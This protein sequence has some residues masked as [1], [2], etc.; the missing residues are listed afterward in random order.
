MAGNSGAPDAIGEPVT[1]LDE[2]WLETARGT[3]KESINSLEEAPHHP[4]A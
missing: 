2:F 1:D 4:S 3:I